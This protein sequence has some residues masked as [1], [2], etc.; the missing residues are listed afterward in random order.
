MTSDRKLIPLQQAQAPYFVGIDLGGTNIKFGLV[1]DRGETLAELHVPTEVELGPEE[2]ARRMG[3]AVA[4][5]A[6][7]A[8]I[9]KSDIAR[10]G[11]ATPGTMDVPA[12]MLLKPHNLPGWFDF[13]IRDRVSHHAGIPVTYANDANAAAYG[14]FWCG[15][16]REY[17]SLILLTLGTGVGG[18]IILGDL[19]IDG[20]H[21]AGG[22]AGHITIDCAADARMC[23]CGRPGH[24]EAYAS[25]TAVV[26]RALEAL[27][28]GATSSLSSLAQN[29]DELTALRIAQAAEGGDEFALEIVL[30][31]AR[32][33]GIGI[34]TLV[35]VI[36]PAGVVLGGA[37]T[38]GEHETE[39]GRRFLARIKQEVVARSLEPIGENLVIDF[40][41][42]GGDAGYIGAAGLA[43]IQHKI[44]HR[45]SG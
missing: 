28:A 36:D 20:E 29:G 13:P 12:G 35:H 24:L 40:A 4:T 41:T 15:T 25:A 43:R 33:L 31:T 1:D 27:A 5:L 16:G 26:Q 9:E 23:A 44:N 6:K 39:L 37:M 32:Y 8:G 3:Q 18:G 14:E 30:E 11:L 22:E 10:V 38:F 17:E 7:Q 19:V 34:A 21:S 42:L 45:I 2:G